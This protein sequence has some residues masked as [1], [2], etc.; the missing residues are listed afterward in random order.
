[1]N[2]S[3]LATG[4]RILM[5]HEDCD[6]AIRAVAAEIKRLKIV[7]DTTI[8]DEEPDALDADDDNNALWVV[9]NRTLEIAGETVAEWTRCSVGRYGS[10]GDWCVEEDTEGN[11]ELPDNVA[12]ALD[13]LGL[14]DEIPD[15]EEPARATDEHT[16]DPEGEY[17]LYWETVGDDAG[18]RARYTTREAAE[19]V[20][21]QRNREFYGRNPCGGGTSYL[22][23]FS[24]RQLVDGK[25]VTGE[26]DD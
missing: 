18:P 20:C 6:D 14:A 17:C 19:A 11:D 2:A 5:S 9:S 24:T 3:E 23:G 26:E 21:D 15:V 22:C 12:V 4:L 7:A 10:D 25:W 8:D 16:P 13:A 1:M